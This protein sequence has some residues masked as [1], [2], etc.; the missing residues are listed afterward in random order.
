MFTRDKGMLR[1]NKRTLTHAK[2][3][4]TW[5]YVINPCTSA[6]KCTPSGII[7]YSSMA[8]AKGR[9]LTV[10]KVGGAHAPQP[11]PHVHHDVRLD[12]LGDVE[13]AHLLG[14]QLVG[15]GHEEPAVGG[16]GQSQG[17]HGNGAEQQRQAG[18]CVQG[19]A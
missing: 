11:R 15:F 12:G 9:D 18:E 14:C 4:F 17:H 19:A 7:T 1:D 8:A 16:H 13:L 3:V 6:V 5:Q 2:R 10:H